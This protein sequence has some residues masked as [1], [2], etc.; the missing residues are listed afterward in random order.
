VGYEQLAQALGSTVEGQFEA[1]EIDPGSDATKAE[2]IALLSDVMTTLERTKRESDVLASVDDR[3]AS[4]V[5]TFL[6]RQSGRELKWLGDVDKGLEAK[7]DSKDILGWAGSLIDWVKGLKKRDFIE[8]DS[9]PPP[10]PNK[11]R[12]AVLSDWGTGLYGGP[13]C[14]RSIE[15]DNK[16][17]NLLLHLGDVYYSGDIEE[18]EER[19]LKFW[20]KVPGAISRALNSNHEMYSGGYGYFDRILPAFKQKSS[21]FAFQNDYWLL[22]G[23]DTGYSE[24]EL[25]GSQA[26]WLLKLVKNAGDRRVVLF[27]H[28]QPYS[29]YEKQGA[30]LVRQ[31]GKL[32]DHQ[33]IHAWYWGHEHRCVVYDQHPIWGVL[34]RCVGH[35]A[36][37]YFRDDFDQPLAKP[38]WQR[39]TGRNLVPGGR[40]LDGPNQYVEDN[41]KKYGPNGYV[42]LEFEDRDLKE[43][44]LN[45]DGTPIP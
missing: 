27:S 16:K 28:H 35:S 1:G 11:A 14:A 12:I 34:G 3:M 13:V 10:L 25:Y 38:G 8:D 37:P 31:I 39:V 32:L 2:A 42:V 22:V 43:V 33:K 20:P 7:F 41:G 18:V 45:P 26:E 44:F 30:A 40:V 36:F 6:S 21:Y 23:L 4:L 15:A 24:H 19:F 29:L 17:F 5:Q 9:T